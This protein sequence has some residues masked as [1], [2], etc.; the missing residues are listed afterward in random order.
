MLIHHTGLIK[1]ELD[2]GYYEQRKSLF[3]LIGVGVFM[4]MLAFSLFFVMQTLTRSVLSDEAAFLVDHSYHT[5]SLLYLIV[6][7]LAFTFYIILRFRAVTYHEVHENTWYGLLHMKYRVS[8]LVLSKLAVQLGSVL[9]INT[10]GFLTTLLMSSVLKFPFILG[11]LV[12]MF[13]ACS[14]NCTLLLLF[15]MTI[16]LF[17]ADLSNARTLFGIGALLLVVLQV[18]TGY[19]ALIADRARISAVSALFTE[20]AFFYLF[21]LLAGLCLLLSVMRASRIGRLYNPPALKTPPPI[22]MPAG[23]RLILRTD[24]KNPAIKRFQKELEDVYKLR[25]GSGAV[26]AILTALLVMLVVAMLAIDAVILAFSYASP[27]KETAVMGF[28]P[29]I[30]QSTTMEPHVFYNDIAFFEKI[31]ENVLLYAE[32]I[33]LYKDDVGAVQ[34]RR[35][36]ERY[37]DLNTGKWMLD[38]DITYYPEGTTIGILHDYIEEGAVYGRLVGTN[39]WLGAIILFANTMLGR[40]LFLL[41][42]T[43]LVFFNKQITDFFK[44]LTPEGS[45]ARRA[46]HEHKK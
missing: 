42:P 28:I 5:T 22:D 36:N 25:R 18:A 32:D 26:S 9:I 45:A 40:I 4:G 30:F 2:Y 6:S 31:D 20:N 29:Y 24:S 13:V 23:T 17:V 27:Q 7:Y 1:K 15:A 3:Q 34:V 33:V 21:V 14:M 35:I 10:A 11:Y 41:V 19:Y 12:T 37:E 38:V 8:A 46:E 43:V 16:S 39:R 44:R